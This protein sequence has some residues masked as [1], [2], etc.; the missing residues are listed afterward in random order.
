MEQKSRAYKTLVGA[1]LIA[2]LNSC[3]GSLVGVS[4]IQVTELI[5]CT[6]TQ[7]ALFFTTYSIAMF[8]CSLLLNKFVG[9]LGYKNCMY[10]GIVVLAAAFV[11]LS[12]SSSV[13]MLWIAG[14]C[15]GIAFILSGSIML[16]VVTT[17]WFTGNTA[18][19]LG[20]TAVVPSLFS[21]VFAT[22]FTQLM[23]KIGWRSATLWVTVISCAI[24]LLCNIFLVSSTPIKYGMEPYHVGGKAKEKKAKRTVEPARDLAMPMSRLMKMPVVWLIFLCPL[25]IGFTANTANT[26][27]AFILNTKLDDPSTIGLLISLRTGINMLV[28]PLFGILC[29]RTGP[30]VPMILYVVLSMVSCLACAFVGG[31]AGALLF[32]ICVPFANISSYFGSM[33]GPSLVGRE[34]AQHLIGYCT[35]AATV[36]GIVVSPIATA[37]ASAFGGSYTVWFLICT[38]LSI[39]LLCVIQILFSKKTKD[40]I[41]KVDAEYAAPNPVTAN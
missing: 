1:V 21:M 13:W 3:I 16:Q 36:S 27:G 5:G 8:L 28:I 33:V 29:D 2:S 26:I 22:A 9:K 30:K 7:S 12:F 40:H 37:V 41:Q 19:V 20:I 4:L 32:T 23:L 25:L 34:K 17:S 24:M 14:V 18:T 31:L 38:A 39:I 6:D 15:A 35:A 11:A 10:L